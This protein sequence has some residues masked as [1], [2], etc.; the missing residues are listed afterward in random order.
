M[1]EHAKAT[2]M[3]AVRD[4]DRGRRFYEGTLGLK[5]VGPK[6]DGYQIYQSGD[7]RLTIYRSQ[8]AGTN[9]ATALAWEVEDAE[10][11]VRDLK[12]KGVTFEHYDLPGTERQGDVHV[13]GG[14]KNA[15]FRDPDGNILS[16]MSEVEAGANR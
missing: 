10:A 8:Y 1:F 16:V 11:A 13:G 7:S 5:P 6:D 4:L 15:W 12:T 14:I 3:I 9:K 2:P